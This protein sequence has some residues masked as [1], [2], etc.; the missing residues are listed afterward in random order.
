MDDDI[1]AT[2]RTHEDDFIDTRPVTDI[3]S[4]VGRLERAVERLAAVTTHAHDRFAEVLVPSESKRELQG[5]G[6]A[7]PAGECDVSRSIHAIIDE[8]ERQTSRLSDMNDRSAV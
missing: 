3:G 8:L 2:V 1:R 7:R 5:D 4:A 6:D